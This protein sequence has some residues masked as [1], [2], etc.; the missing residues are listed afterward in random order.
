MVKKLHIL[1]SGNFIACHLRKSFLS[2]V[3]MICLCLCMC[4]S[5]SAVARDVETDSYKFDVGVSAGMSGYLGDANQSNVFKHPGFAAALT[6][7]YLFAD[8]R[9]ALRAVL[10]T[11]SLSGSTSDLSGVVPVE[12]PI[13]FKSQIYDLGVRGEANFFPY[14]I[15]RTYQRLRRWTPYLAV[16]VGLTMASCEGKMYTAMSI[17]MAVGVKYK[18]K[19]RLNLAVEWCMTRTLGDHIDGEQLSDLFMIKSEFMKNCDWH[20][21]LTLSITYEFGKRCVTCHRVD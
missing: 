10:A 18:L 17:P 20:S 14:G 19:P 4:V 5:E 7:R 9:W 16:G 2:A 3:A 12:A 6:G 15:G 13:D 8:T 21:S 11:A 1:R